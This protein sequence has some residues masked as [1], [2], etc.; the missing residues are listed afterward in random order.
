MGKTQDSWRGKW[1][2]MMNKM[3]QFRSS[4]VELLSQ[5]NQVLL[6]A[7]IHYE[8]QWLSIDPHLQM[9]KLLFSSLGSVGLAHATGIVK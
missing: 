9:E 7:I 1:L 3:G 2:Y 8:L 6:T 5:P 4:D